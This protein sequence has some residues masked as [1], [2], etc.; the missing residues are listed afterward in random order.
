VDVLVLLVVVAV[1]FAAQLVDGALGMGYGV[2]SMSLLLAAGLVP[3]VASAT[4]HIAKIGTALA[5][6][7]AHWRFGNVDGT[8]TLL[9]GIPGAVGA[10][11]GAVVLSGLTLSAARPYVSLILLALGGVIIVRFL[12]GRRVRRAAE[13]AA[14]EAVATE[15]VATEAPDE[16]PKRPRWMLIPLGLIGGFV[17][18]S[19]GGGWGP[20]TTSTLVASGRLAPRTTIGT[21]NA[22]ELAVAVA[23]SVGF[24]HSLGS[25]GVRWDVT[26]AMLLGGVLAA[27]PA[28]WLVRHI[29][30]RSLGLAVGVLILVLSAESVLSLLQLPEPILMGLRIAGLAVTLV[31]LAAALIRANSAPEAA[32]RRRRFGRGPAPAD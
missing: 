1:G 32:D 16:T 30:E 25:A 28:A 11:V 12:H 29:N 4:V 3:A 17:D 23:A 22:A 5:S 26:A 19:G 13:T 21:V 27:A 6:G 24:L 2:L 10:Y 15:T 18:A 7:L 14:V 31:L 20:V 8:I 9:L